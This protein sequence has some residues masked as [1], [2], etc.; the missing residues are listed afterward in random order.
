MVVQMA[1]PLLFNQLVPKPLVK[2]Y[3]SFLTMNSFKLITFIKGDV[4]LAMVVSRTGKQSSLYINLYSLLLQLAWQSNLTHIKG[5]LEWI[6][7]RHDGSL[8]VYKVRTAATILL[9]TI[10]VSMR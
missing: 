1:L 2:V 5:K 6:R 4:N 8:S 3:P 10:S 7:E 9:A